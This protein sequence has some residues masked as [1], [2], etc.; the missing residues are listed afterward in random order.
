MHLQVD[1]NFS[2]AAETT[3]CIWKKSTRSSRELFT[4]NNPNNF[5][6]LPAFTSPKTPLQP[7]QCRSSLLIQD[8]TSKQD[9]AFEI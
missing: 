5:G 7:Y 8:C 3:K 4:S 1:V 9:F 2:A 6:T